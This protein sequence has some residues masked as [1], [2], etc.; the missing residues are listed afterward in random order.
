MPILRRNKDK[1]EAEEFRYRNNGLRNGLAAA[2]CSRTLIAERKSLYPPNRKFSIA[3]IASRR[4]R[5][6]GCCSMQLP[7]EGQWISPPHDR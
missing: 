3:E 2:A 6:R 4:R 7:L 1:N 5:I